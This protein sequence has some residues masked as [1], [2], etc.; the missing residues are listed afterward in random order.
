MYIQGYGGGRRKGA[1]RVPLTFDLYHYSPG[2]DAMEWLN[3]MFVLVPEGAPQS[4]RIYLAVNG[5][6]DHREGVNE[7]GPAGC[8][9]P[10]MI[11]T[12]V[13]IAPTL[14]HLAAIRSNQTARATLQPFFHFRLDWLSFNHGDKLYLFSPAFASRSS[15]TSMIRMQMPMTAQV[16]VVFVRKSF[17][18]PSISSKFS[19]FHSHSEDASIKWSDD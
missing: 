19:G 10:D 13:I 6:N 16:S 1:E 17:K 15:F 14:I 18:L 12:T 4:Q 3:P 2:L 11:I 8:S 5:W 7:S 9:N